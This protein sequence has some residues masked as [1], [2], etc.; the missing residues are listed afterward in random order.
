MQKGVTK[1]A[2]PGSEKVTGNS[3]RNLKTFV[4]LPI[5]LMAFFY[6][7]HALL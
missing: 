3:K 5:I 1:T 7:F 6:K 4:L 2:D